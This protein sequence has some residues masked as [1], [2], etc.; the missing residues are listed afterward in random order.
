MSTVSEVLDK[1]VQIQNTRGYPDQQMADKIGCSRP[2]Y[3]RT[4]T[5]K[6]PVGGTFLKGAIRFLES[7]NNGTRS[8]VINRRT[9]E[10]DISVEIDIDGAGRYEIDTGITFFDHMLA[11]MARH[12]LFDI[13]IK[14]SGD[15]THHLVEDVA[16][17][18]GKAF[19]EA[20]GEKRGIVRM[21]GVSVP[22]DEALATVIIDIGGRGY[23]VLDLAFTGNDITG[24]AAD[25]VRHFLESFAFE[26]RINLHAK[27]E[28]GIND[29]HKAEALFKALA[30]ALD[31]ATRIDPRTGGDLPTT[32][33]HLEK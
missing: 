22:M 6:I 30:R 20:L 3:Q 2:L 10:T 11:Q 29:H 24:F 4:R 16:I 33:G 26:A 9:S 14:A 18:L 17:C 21:F 12:G 1:V 28:Y 8:A 32:K 23:T 7:E 27:I 5:G 25:L 19:A 31:S 15:D 13:K